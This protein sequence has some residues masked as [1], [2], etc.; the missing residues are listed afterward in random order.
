[1]SVKIAAAY[2][3]VSTDDQV[4]YSPESQISKI[5][6]LA[7]RDGYL[8]PDEY[9]YQDDGISGKLADKRPAFRL[10]IATAKQ[11]LPPFDRIYVWEFSRFARNQEESI[12][13]KNLLRR[14]GI[15]VKSVREP[16]S[17]SPFSSLI[18]RI[19]EW[20]DEYYV[21]NLAEEVRRGMS[22]KA[23]RGEA[24]G[25]APFGYTC[26]NKTF[27]PNEHA[28]TVRYIFS[29]YLSGAGI[30]SLAAEL[31]AQGIRT[32]RGNLPD[33]RWVSY[34]LSNPVYIGKIRWSTKG[35]ANYDRANYND[36][37]VMLVD[38]KHEPIIDTATWDAVQAKLSTRSHEAKYVRKNNPHM[39]M[40][41]G[42]L[43]C[44]D[45]GSTLTY[46]SSQE[47][48]VQCHKY[49]KGQC[50]VS[51]HISIKQANATV[52]AALE[53]IAAS[54][55]YT[56]TP[57]R[58]KKQTIVHEWEKLISSEELKLQRAKS[59]LLEGAFT[60]SE[61][62]SIRAEIEETIEKL[63]A[64]RDAET[65]ENTQSVDLD[66]YTKKVLEVLAIVNSPDVSELRK[67]EALRSILDK[68]LYY[69]S[70][71][72]FELFFNS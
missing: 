38:G 63:K 22:E 10:M 58:P 64:G 42:L 28:D 16:L 9:F 59:A 26:K 34:I 62:K 53:D 50:H 44:S 69:K 29:A 8:V 41:K 27:Y 23:G 40:L 18:E 13:Y 24:M 65:A 19:I 55:S 39:F 36:T 54:R 71:R 66:A 51:H 17:D 21:I 15:S 31:G 45:C 2:I 30:R 11:D 20:M 47:P 25:T 12:M 46:Q 7:K 67:N 52:V 3:R 49:A 68:V 4:E 33:N 70:P 6:E 14:K 1:M 5:K 60:P 48:A 32:R 61:Y 37:N 43:R 56:F 57:A 72:R 35:H